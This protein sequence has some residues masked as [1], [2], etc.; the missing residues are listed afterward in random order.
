MY[1]YKTVGNMSFDTRTPDKVCEILE[2]VSSKEPYTRLRLYYGDTETGRCWMDEHDT[3]GSIGR[4]TGR[5][6]IP[7]LIKTRRSLGGTAILD[8]RI[9][10]I[11]LVNGAVLYK[12][13]LFNM[14]EV[15]A[16]GCTVFMD[17]KTYANCKTDMQA[18][19]LAKFLSGDIDTKGGRYSG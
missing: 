8:N 3:V 17:G 7:L 2:Y 18:E 5:Y 19:R 9:I 13:P 10:K 14:P 11:T 1:E 12:H 15:K 6:K 4:S 16:D